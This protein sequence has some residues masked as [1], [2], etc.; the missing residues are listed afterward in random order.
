[1]TLS[2]MDETI[3]RALLTKGNKPAAIAKLL[4]I[5]P[6]DLAPMVEEAE[7]ETVLVSEVQAGNPD[8]TFG[9]WSVDF[10]ERHGN[11][12]EF[13]EE[14]PWLSISGYCRRNGIRKGEFKSSVPTQGTGRPRVDNSEERLEQAARLAKQMADNDR[15]KNLKLCLLEGMVAVGVTDIN[16]AV[17]AAQ[18][19]APDLW[20][21]RG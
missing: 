12:M 14:K 15:K 18:Q 13:S 16:G 8:M 19:V 6:E 5:D 20:K 10:I 7:Y 3:A 17:K 2:T 9:D 21:P 4:D 1:M 11:P